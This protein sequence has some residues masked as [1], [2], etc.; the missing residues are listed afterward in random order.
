MRQSFFLLLLAAAGCGVQVG[1]TLEPVDISG[2]VTVGD[3]PVSNVILNFQPT[4]AGTL[5][6]MIPIKDGKFET[7]ASP[8]RYAWYFEETK[9]GKNAK[10]FEAIPVEYRAADLDRQIDVSAGAELEFAIE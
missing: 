3:K 1:K 6:V 9:D 2:S 4:G 5:P 8:G 7:T 10:E